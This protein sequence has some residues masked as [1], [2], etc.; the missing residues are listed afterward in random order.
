MRMFGR[1]VFPSTSS[2]ARR[3]IRGLFE[4]IAVAAL[5][6]LMQLTP[7]IA[8]AGASDWEANVESGRVE[9]ARGNHERATAILLVAIKEAETAGDS[10][11]RLPYVLNLLGIQHSERGD[12]AAAEPL[13]NRAL[14]IREKEF[15]AASPEVANSL[16]NLAI[17]YA[18][19]RNFEPAETFLKRAA[20]IW[21]QAFGRLHPDMARILNSLAT[22][23][24][25]QDKSDQAELLLRRA[26]EIA[27]RTGNPDNTVAALKRLSELYAKMG[28]QDDAVGALERAASV[29]ARG[30]EVR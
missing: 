2:K 20:D 24:L 16:H 5:S 30:K 19:Q 3:Q 15:G 23:Y 26:I 22:V 9:F 29:V 25:A 4:A 8:Y 13:L 18:G 27:E 12:Y 7:S 17:L 14:A 10:D 11:P 28:R 1:S 21:E 6:V